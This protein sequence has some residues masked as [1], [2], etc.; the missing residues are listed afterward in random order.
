MIM[1]LLDQ[2]FR[3]WIDKPQRIGLANQYETKIS[4]DR[5]HYGND[6]KE[7]IRK[8]IK[9]ADV[10]LAFWSRDAVKGGREQFHYEVYQ[11]MMQRKL[12][13]CRIDTVEFDEIGMP[14]TFDH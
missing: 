2:G 10:V 13:Q 3:L 14:Y 9:K 4:L 7:D 5:I 11:G 8:A 1:A 12:N 6:W